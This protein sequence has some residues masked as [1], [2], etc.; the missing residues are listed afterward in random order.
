MGLDSSFPYS[1]IASYSNYSLIASFLSH[2]RWLW[3]FHLLLAVEVSYAAPSLSAIEDSLLRLREATASSGEPYEAPAAQDVA[4]LRA[5]EEKLSLE[6]KR[7]RQQ[8][9]RAR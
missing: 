8:L 5:V 1:L 2:G 3:A 7:L 4:A 9:R 6:N